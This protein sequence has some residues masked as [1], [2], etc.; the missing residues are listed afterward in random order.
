MLELNKTL[1]RIKD[2]HFASSNN[3][4]YTEYNMFQNLYFLKSFPTYFLNNFET[5][6][7]EKHTKI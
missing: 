1:K 2:N 4:L 6:F 7:I 5:I 3:L